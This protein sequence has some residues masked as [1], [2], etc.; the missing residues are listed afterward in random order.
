M[1]KLVNIIGISSLFLSLVAF[2]SLSFY[3]PVSLEDDETFFVNTQIIS[4]TKFNLLSTYSPIFIGWSRTNFTPNGSVLRTRELFQESYEYVL[5]SLFISCIYLKKDSV[6]FVILSYDILLVTPE[7]AFSVKKE[8]L[9]RGISNVYFSASH[10]HSSLGG[11]GKGLVSEIALGEFDQSIFD[12][13]IDKT[14]VTI[15]KAIL[16]QD[17]LRNISYTEKK[18]NNA[19]NRLIKKDHV[20]ERLRQVCFSSTAHI[21]VMSSLNIHPTFVSSKRNVISKDYPKIFSKEKANEFG[22]FVA[23]AMGSIKP[24]K[25]KKD[26]SQITQFKA[27]ID[28]KPYAVD[29]STV[30]TDLIGFT[31]IKMETPFLSPLLTQNI[32]SSQ[33]LSSVLIGKP[34]ISIEVLRIGEVLMIALPCELSSEFYP[35]LQKIAEAKG[36]RLMIT[37]FN[38]SYL[39]YATPS[40]N[41]H[42]DH[43]ETRTMNW[44]GKYGGDYFNELVRL[45]IEK[46]P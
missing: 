12:N 11:Y 31:S 3:S 6:Q 5:D 32:C 39:G 28:A 13:I 41:F 17:T 40:R 15:D 4:K 43:M 26:T 36:L 25:I 16:I 45:I 21:A 2:L 42:I 37:S 35:E 29:D 38:G 1:K 20:E 10:T 23:G 18:I 46:Q 9:S 44:T 22:I 27:I 14:I 33:L 34:E 7:L 19:I 8:L 30:R 24:M